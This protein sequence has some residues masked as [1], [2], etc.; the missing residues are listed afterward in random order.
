MIT[1]DIRYDIPLYIRELQSALRDIHFL[2]PAEIPLINIDGIFGPETT[3]VV[4]AA[5]RLG[6]R[7]ATGIVDYETWMW[8]F[9]VRRAGISQSGTVSLLGR[10]IPLDNKNAVANAVQKMLVVLAGTFPNLAAPP[11]GGMADQATEL[12]LTDFAKI[13]QLDAEQHPAEEVLRHLARLYAA[14]VK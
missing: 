9:A 12:A 14:Y 4:L 1:N 6:G 13:A 5:Q 7:E 8:L 3:E 10:A 11:N 2:Y